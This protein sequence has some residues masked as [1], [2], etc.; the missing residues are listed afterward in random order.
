[1]TGAQK[2]LELILARNLL[3]SISTPA[4]LVGEQGALL[5]FN[6][7]AAAMLGRRFEESGMMSAQEWTTEFGPFDA[8]EA[9]MTYDEI[10]ATIAIRSKRPFHGVFRIRSATGKHRDVAASAIPIV[11]AAGASGAIVIFWPLAE[12]DEEDSAADG[13][14]EGES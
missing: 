13:P 2:P 5:F 14:Q 8:D 11:G 4:L 10:P 9:P 6:E 1:M 3:S 7:G 12:D